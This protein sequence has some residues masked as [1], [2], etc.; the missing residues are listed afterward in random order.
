MPFLSSP[1]LCSAL[2]ASPPLLYSTLLYSSLLFSSLLYSTPL[3]Y[4][5][6]YLFFLLSTVLLS[7]PLLLF[8]PS[9]LFY[10]S[11][12][13]SSHVFSCLLVSYYYTSSYRHFL[14]PRFISVSCS[15]CTLS[16]SHLSTV[17][18]IIHPFIHSFIHPLP[19]LDRKIFIHLLFI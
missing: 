2:F 4:L 13:A 18:L 10:S 16:L 14:L 3:S 5:S 7:S 15:I 11:C 19:L 17:F 8:K 1:L 6:S 9:T 12:I